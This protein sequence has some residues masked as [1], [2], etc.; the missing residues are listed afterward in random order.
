MID[1][2]GDGWTGNKLEISSDSSFQ[3]ATL[4]SGFS[5]SINLNFFK[6]DVVKMKWIYN[7]Y[8]GEAS[9]KFDGTGK[10]QLVAD[11][12]FNDTTS[13]TWYGSGYNPVNGI[14]HADTVTAG[15]QWALSLSGYVDL[16]AGAA[17]TLSFD[18]V[19]KAGRTIVAGIGQSV[20]PYLA[21]V[22][23]VTLSDTLQSIVLQLTANGEGTDF[24]GD[25]SRVIF[26]MGA[27][28]GVVDIDN[29]VLISVNQDN[30]FSGQH[31]T[32]L[33]F[34]ANCN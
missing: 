15:D 9:Y 12:T 28:T 4:D 33:S 27:D 18:V 31:D 2:Y 10:K 30:T 32:D 7:N 1:S 3:S 25:T 29:V 13:T 6:G 22:K 20:H 11:G 17:Y 5:A 19:G 24:G 34:I 23:E 21:D 8:W 14:N 26:D 16:T